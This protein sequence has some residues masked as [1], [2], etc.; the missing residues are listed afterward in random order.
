MLPSPFDG[1]RVGDGGDS[2]PGF[3]RRGLREIVR[4]RHIPN[5][6]LPPSK[7][8]GRDK[9]VPLLTRCLVWVLGAQLVLLTLSAIFPPDA[10]PPRPAVLARGAGPARRLAAGPAGGRWPLADPNGPRPHGPDLPEAPDRRRGCAVL[11]PPWRRSAGGGPRSGIR[12]WSTGAPPPAST[13]TMQTA[14]LLEP[15]PRNLGSKLIEMIRAVQLES[16]ADQ[17]RDPG[18]VPDPRALWR[19]SGRRACRQPGLFRP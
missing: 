7:G 8:E 11:Q 19:Q 15:R 1:G 10:D 16:A 4:R 18:A 14:R 2:V 3:P 13:L 5:P 17:A 12:R 9:F 6:A